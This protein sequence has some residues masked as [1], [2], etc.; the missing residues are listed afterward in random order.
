LPLII[1]IGAEIQTRMSTASTKSGK[2]A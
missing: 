2:N 1:W